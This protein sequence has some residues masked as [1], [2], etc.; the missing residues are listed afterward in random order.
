MGSMRGEWNAWL[1]RSRFD[2]AKSFA[3]VVASS[4]SPEITT[5]VGP[6]RAAMDTFS[7]SK[8]RTSSSVACTATIAPP[9]G[10]ACMSRPRAATSAAA[11]SSDQTPAT[12]AAASSPMEWPSR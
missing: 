10:R 3:I 6:L 11:S 9:S 5:E 1:T 7:V 8:G 2:F 12:C 4:S